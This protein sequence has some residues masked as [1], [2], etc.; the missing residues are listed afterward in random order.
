M[1]QEVAQQDVQTGAIRVALALAGERIGLPVMYRTDE[2]TGRTFALMPT[3][4][5][6]RTVS[7]CVCHTL[8]GIVTAENVYNSV[9][10][11]RPATPTEFRALQEELKRTYAGHHLMGYEAYNVWFNRTRGKNVLIQYGVLE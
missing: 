1:Q 3:L 10:D 5:G 4:P 9:R 8:G 11:T 2:L 6:E 7:K